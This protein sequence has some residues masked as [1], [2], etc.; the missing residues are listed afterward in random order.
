MAMSE[1]PRV[2]A[3]RRADLILLDGNPLVDIGNVRRIRAVVFRGEVFGRDRLD[4]L[5]E[6]AAG[7]AARFGQP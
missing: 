3:G 4:S 1:E 5:L 7:V 6:A 2:A